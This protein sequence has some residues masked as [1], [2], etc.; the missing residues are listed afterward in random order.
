MCGAIQDCPAIRLG[1]PKVEGNPGQNWLQ[2]PGQSKFLLGEVT[3]RSVDQVGVMVASAYVQRYRQVM[4][5]SPRPGQFLPSAFL[6]AAGQSVRNPPEGLGARLSGKRVPTQQRLL[7]KVIAAPR[8]FIGYVIPGPA[9]EDM[10]LPCRAHTVSR[11]ACT[12][13]RL[14]KQIQEL[15]LVSRGHPE[16]L[17]KDFS[18][19]LQPR[20]VL[21]LITGHAC[22]LDLDAPGGYKNMLSSGAA[23]VTH[24]DVRITAY[25][26]RRP[27]SIRLI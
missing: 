18:Q 19:K 12:V 14:T 5:D 1:D 23:A 13:E 8:R 25:G 16:R 9:A 20:P 15:L 6:A 4:D 3:V 2:Q 24:P 10:V 11:A 17:V 22:I 21:L 27:S 7:S 26:G